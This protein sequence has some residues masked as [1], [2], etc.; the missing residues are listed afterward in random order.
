MPA[1]QARAKRLIWVKLW[2]GMMPGT[3]SASIP[4][5]TQASRKRRILVGV[6]AVLA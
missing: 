1:P 3:Y 2:I 4:A 5:A 6:E